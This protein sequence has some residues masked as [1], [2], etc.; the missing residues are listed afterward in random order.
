MKTFFA[1]MLMF[2]IAL[3]P[4]SSSVAGGKQKA[5]NFSLKTE[6]GKTIE[7]SKLKGKIVV[8]NFW[9]TWCPPCRAEIPGFIDLYKNYKNK[10]VEIVGI[11]LD[12]NGWDAVTPFLQ[13]N[14]INYPIVVGNEEIADS[15][16]SIEAIPTT[17]IID[18][19]GYIAEHHIGY[20]EK[21]KLEKILKS[22]L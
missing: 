13:K 7:L 10:G 2:G 8:V 20:F 14:N 22:L 16:G 5:P 21:E 3:M 9:A 1:S 6:G 17:F 18:K 19:N 12:Q 15:Y 4:A 11:S